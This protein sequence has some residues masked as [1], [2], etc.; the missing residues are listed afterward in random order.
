MK[1]IPWLKFT[2]YHRAILTLLESESELEAEFEAE[3]SLEAE[4]E[5]EAELELWHWSLFSFIFPLNFFLAFSFATF[6]FF[7]RTS[8]LSPP[9]ACIQAEQQWPIE[10]SFNSD[11]IY[12]RIPYPN[13][14]YKK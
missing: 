10:N 3:S 11:R 14:I 7:F 8:E 2:C 5:S 9:L 6:F 4:A 13:Y 1:S 12:S